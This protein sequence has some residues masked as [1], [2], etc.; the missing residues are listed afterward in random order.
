[1]SKLLECRE[2]EQRE[3]EQRE[4]EQREVEQVREDGKIYNI[5]RN[6]SGG[7]ERRVGNR[8]EDGQCVILGGGKSIEMVQ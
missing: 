8:M 4:V 6:P 7:G 1:M 5:M 2:V 3:V